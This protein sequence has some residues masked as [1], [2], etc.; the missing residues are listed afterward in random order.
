MKHFWQMGE[1]QQFHRQIRGYQETI[2]MKYEK[3][4][5]LSRVTLCKKFKLGSVDMLSSYLTDA[6]KFK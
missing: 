3:I 6:V 2:R 1:I 5:V 4:S